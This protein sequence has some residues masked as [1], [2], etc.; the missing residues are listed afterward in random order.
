MKS[1]LLLMKIPWHDGI[2]FKL[3]TYSVEG[4]LLSPLK[5]YLENRE[6]R[7]ILNDQTSEWRKIMS[8]IPQGSVLLLWRWTTFATQKLSWKPRTKNC[9]KWP[10][11]WVEKNNVWNSTRISTIIVQNVCIWYIPLFEGLWHNKSASKHN[12][13]FEKRS[14]W[15][16]QWKM[17]FNPDPNKQA[18]KVIFS[19]KT[20]SNDLSHP[21]IKFNNN[22]ISKCSH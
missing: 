21:L 3:K 22:D 11:I 20:S 8:G 13:D 9:L 14:Y 4:E 15:A 12:D 17:Q 2:I 16:Y 5:N 18:N 1:K 10:N 6:Q 7:I 19:R